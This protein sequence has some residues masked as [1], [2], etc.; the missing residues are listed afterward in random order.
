MIHPL[1]QVSLIVGVLRG[2]LFD[3]LLLAELVRG[4]E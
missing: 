4:A 3:D 1:A 2:S